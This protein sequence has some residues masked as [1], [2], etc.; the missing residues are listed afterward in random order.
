MRLNQEHRC[1]RLKTKSWKFP[2]N[3][4]ISFD[5]R[6]SLFTRDNLV[7][8]SL[9]PSR[10]NQSAEFPVAPSLTSMSKLPGIILVPQMEWRPLVGLSI[11]MRPG[12]P[13]RNVSLII[14]QRR[15]RCPPFFFINIHPLILHKVA[16]MNGEIN[17]K[18]T[19]FRNVSHSKCFS[20]HLSFTT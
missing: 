1:P 5:H 9:L 4:F 19:I 12:A 16:L 10:Y 18:D 11:G 6:G 15:W 7:F 14:T 20:R 17:P 13:E 8:C 2:K 3:G